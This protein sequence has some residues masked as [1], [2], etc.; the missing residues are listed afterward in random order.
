M[1]YVDWRIG[2]N[3][4]S[5]RTTSRGD[6]D[7]RERAAVDWDAALEW[8]LTNVC[9]PPLPVKYVPTCK[10]ALDVFAVVGTDAGGD[11][12]V[13]VDLPEGLTWRGNSQAPASVIVDFWNLHSF[14]DI[15]WGDYEWWL[16]EEEW[17]AKKWE[18]EEDEEEEYV[19]AVDR[20]EGSG[21]SY[22]CSCPACGTI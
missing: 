17:E 11:E 10:A 20:W 15:L 18:A 16:E 5:V 12:H 14:V 7:V 3:I 1:V 9:D 13:P 19:S 8:H 6:T 2:T 22:I 21:H 4:P